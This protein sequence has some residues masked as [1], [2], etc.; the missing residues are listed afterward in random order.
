MPL[1]L[2][3]RRRLPPSL[4]LIFLFLDG[5]RLF[6]LLFRSTICTTLKPQLQKSC[7]ETR[8]CL[9]HGSDALRLASLLERCPVV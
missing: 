9:F 6:V 3:F 2:K 7:R 5:L 8:R 4:L 1:R